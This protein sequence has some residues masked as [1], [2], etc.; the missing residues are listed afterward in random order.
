MFK[1]LVSPGQVVQ[2]GETVIILEAMKMETEV[3]APASGTV[4]SISV[5]EGDAVQVG[6]TL[7]VLN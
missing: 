7:L 3:S 2:E 4:A 6:D 1:V 5:A